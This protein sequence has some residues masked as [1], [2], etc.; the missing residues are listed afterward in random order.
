MPQTSRRRDLFM[1]LAG[2]E[3]GALARSAD[4]PS[5]RRASL[6][7]LSPDGS[8]FSVDSVALP[9]LREHIVT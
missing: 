3:R 1:I 2:A 8:M 9:P 7:P 4:C 5:C 6:K